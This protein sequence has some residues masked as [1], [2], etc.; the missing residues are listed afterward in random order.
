MEYNAAT[1]A[2]ARPSISGKSAAGHRGGSWSDR[3]D[4]SDMSDMSDWS[5]VIGRLPS[6]VWQPHLQRK[7]EM[8]KAES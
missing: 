3:S 1:F 8:G 2:G 7:A 4:M 5:D 6:T